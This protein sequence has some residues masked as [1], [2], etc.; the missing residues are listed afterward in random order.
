[1]KTVFSGLSLLA[2][3]FFLSLSPYAGETGADTGA[4]PA[5]LNVPILL[6]HR[7]GPTVADGMT[8][9]TPVFESHLKYLKDHGYAVIPLRQ[10]VD[11]YLNKGPQP[12]PRSVVIVA[13]DGH[14]SVYKYMLPVVKEYRV[15][16]TLFLYPSAISNA[17]YAMTWDQLR[18]L[19]KTGLFDFQGH[20]Y[21][22]PNFKK[23]EKR[24]S[25]P[26]FEKSVDLQLN[27]SKAKVEKELGVR[28]DML[29]WPFGIYTDW[30][31]GKAKEAGY[32]AAF[33]IEARP[34][35]AGDAMMKL[36]RFLLTNADNGKAFER[37]V[38]GKSG[39]RDSVN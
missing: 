5:A 39:R 36:P 20:T 30:L 28:V 19:K 25:R 22:H 32:V 37:I 26:E 33:S 35:T 15:P 34:A 38:Q 9:T 14:E 24:M 6:Y 11:Y 7:F 3:I 29:A 17:S 10:L 18:E 23:D 8:V 2:V 12:L 31:M 4:N 13:D 1:M 27:R 16:V 21:W